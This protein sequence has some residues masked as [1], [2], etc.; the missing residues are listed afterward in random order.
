LGEGPR[1]RID[2]PDIECLDYLKAFARRVHETYE[3]GAAIKLI[4]TDTHADELNGH[5]R[6]ST[7]EYCAE[8]EVSARSV[9]CMI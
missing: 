3:R 7:H 9:R 4:F 6:Q 2:A 1:C 5:S 8:V